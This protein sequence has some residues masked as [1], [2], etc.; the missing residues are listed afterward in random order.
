MVNVA[1]RYV[2]GFLQANISSNYRLAN[3]SILYL[4]QFLTLDEVV[5]LNSDLNQALLLWK[6]KIILLKGPTSAWF[7]PNG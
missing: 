6:I 2:R 7:T 1:V 5:K 4:E 3:L